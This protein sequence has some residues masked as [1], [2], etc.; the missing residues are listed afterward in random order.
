M[1]AI[2]NVPEKFI[3]WVDPAPKHRAKLKESFYWI[4]LK[5]TLNI[6]KL[7]FCYSDD[8]HQIMKSDQ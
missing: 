6:G 5:R 7:D 1:A 4:A 3:V 8:A 2:K